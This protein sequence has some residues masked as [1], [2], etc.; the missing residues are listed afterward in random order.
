MANVA[1]S[2]VKTTRHQ[3][4]DGMMQT[5][6]IPCFLLTL[7]P[8]NKPVYKGKTFSITVHEHVAVT[9][10]NQT[11][12]LAFRSKPNLALQVK[13]DF[14]AKLLETLA[15]NF[16]GFEN[17]TQKTFS[18]F[19]SMPEYLLPEITPES[20]QQVNRK[21]SKLRLFVRWQQLSWAPFEAGNILRHRHFEAFLKHCSM[22]LMTKL[23]LHQRN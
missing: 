11:D 17:C 20:N 19:L 5:G 18:L 8:Q 7:I 3:L 15:L 1:F 2:C 16:S 6:N 22:S 9:L 10:N 12:K 13:N 4:T 23:H 14:P 21:Q